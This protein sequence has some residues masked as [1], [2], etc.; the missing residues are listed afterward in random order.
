MGDDSRMLHEQQWTRWAMIVGCYMNNNE[1][2]GGDD[3]ASFLSPL[4]RLRFASLLYAVCSELA[5]DRRPA[6][7]ERPPT[8]M[9]ASSSSITSAANVTRGFCRCRGDAWGRG[10]G[11]VGARGVTPD[12]RRPRSSLG[13]R[14]PL[15]TANL[16]DGQPMSGYKLDTNW[17]NSPGTYC[18]CCW[19]VGHV[20]PVGVLDTY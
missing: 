7:R 3:A 14:P 12:G 15:S 16:T 1:L 18:N 20:L 10:G 2:D 6:S 13:S 11:V 4:T 17:P 8:L 9:V 19:C 5:G